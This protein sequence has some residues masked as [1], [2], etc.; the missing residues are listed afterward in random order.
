MYYVVTAVADVQYVIQ[1]LVVFREMGER[2]NMMRVQPRVRLSAKFTRPS[3]SPSQWINDIMEPFTH[4]IL[5][6]VIPRLP[7]SHSACRDI[8]MQPLK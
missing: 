2:Q 8:D 4:S 7:I 5:A 3:L 6:P 1:V